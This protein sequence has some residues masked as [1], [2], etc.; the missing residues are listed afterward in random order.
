MT[1]GLSYNLGFTNAMKSDSEF[2]FRTPVNNNDAFSQKA[3]ANGVVLTI[4][5]LF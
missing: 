5:V 4:G 2:L 1:F 3:N